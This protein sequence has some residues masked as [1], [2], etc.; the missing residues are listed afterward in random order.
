MG[1]L[2]D[3]QLLVQAVPI[4]TKIMSSNPVY[5]EVSPMQYRYYV[6]KFV[7]DLRSVGGFLRVLRFL[8]QYNLP[9]WY[10]WNIIKG[11]V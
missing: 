2:L 7:S 10:N 3:L 5:G 8:H 1:I 4:T 11:G 6:I 9:L